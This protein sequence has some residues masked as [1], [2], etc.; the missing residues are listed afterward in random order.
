MNRRNF[1]SLVG[2]GALAALFKPKPCMMG[3]SFMRL[4]PLTPQEKFQGAM[5]TGQRHSILDFPPL[6]TMGWK[7]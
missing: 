5:L 7:P 3:P 6:P 1:F 4:E 2:L